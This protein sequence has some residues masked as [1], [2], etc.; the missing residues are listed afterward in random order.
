MKRTVVQREANLLDAEEARKYPNEVRRAMLEEFQRW[1]NLGA[2]ERMPKEDASNL[3]DARWVLKWKKIDDK[4]VIQAQ[5]VVRCFED[6][7]ASQL[8][9]FAGTT[10]RW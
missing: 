5:L 10:S 2:F 9:T 8:S 7:Q 4:Y 6:L 1:L 3:I